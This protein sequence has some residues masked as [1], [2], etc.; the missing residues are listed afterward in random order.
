M[1]IK[2]LLVDLTVDRTHDL[3]HS[4]M[5]TIKQL[6]VLV[7][8]GRYLLPIQSVP[9]TTTVVSSNP[10]HWIEKYK[11]NVLFLIS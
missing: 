4:F 9:I 6:G 7:H 10:T 11:F 8:R 3:P 5:N 2:V 1:S